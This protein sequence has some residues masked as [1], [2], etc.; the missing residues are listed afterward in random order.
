MDSPLDGLSNEESRQ[1]LGPI[2]SLWRALAGDKSRTEIVGRAVGICERYR[3]LPEIPSGL[4]RAL[5]WFSEGPEG[6]KTMAA[7]ARAAQLGLSGDDLQRL[8]RWAIS[9]R[10]PAVTAGAIQHW[11]QNWL[12]YLSG[13][14]GDLASRSRLISPSPPLKFGTTSVQY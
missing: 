14:Q 2:S 6:T 11:R 10:H 13:K 1:Y 12:R 9:V 8:A 4:T 3:G 7:A 5:R